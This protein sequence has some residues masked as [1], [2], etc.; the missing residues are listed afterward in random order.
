[1]SCNSTYNNLDRRTRYDSA[2]RLRQFTIWRSGHVQQSQR[3]SALGH[4]RLECFPSRFTE[5]RQRKTTRKPAMTKRSRLKPNRA[6]RFCFGIEFIAVASSWSSSVRRCE[7]NEIAGERVI[8]VIS[9]AVH[10]SCCPATP[11]TASAQSERLEIIFRTTLIS[12]KIQFAVCA[13][14][15]ITGLYCILYFCADIGQA[16]K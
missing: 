2:I 3:A 16:W 14:T 5:N 7:W 8:F 6:W 1:M 13:E 11:V 9:C 4:V 15:R 10:R 12:L